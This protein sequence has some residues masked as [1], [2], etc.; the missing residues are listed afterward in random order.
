MKVKL[1]DIIDLDYLL[2]LD[3]QASTNIQIL[4]RTKR[5]R[6]IYQKIEPKPDNEKNLILSWLKLRKKQFL[7]DKKSKAQH[8]LP[9]MIFSSLYNYMG[10]LMLIFGGFVGITL[11]YSF[12]AYHGEKPINVALYIA[13]F[14]VLQMVLILIT[15]IALIRRYFIKSFENDVVNQGAFFQTMV[16]GFFFHSLPKWL[17]KRDWGIFKKNIDSLEYVAAIIQMKNREYKNLFFWPMF[18]LTSF[19]SLGFSMGALGGTFFRVLISDMAFGWQSTLIT[20]SERVFQLVHFMALPW[21]WLVSEVAAHPSLAQIEGSRIILKDGISVLATQDLISWWPF[22]CFSV[23]V[24]AVIPRLGLSIFSFFAQRRKI[25]TYVFTQPL[26]RQLLARMMSPVVDIESKETSVSQT[27]RKKPNL[28]TNNLESA[29]FKPD[30]NLSLKDQTIE[31]LLS[32]QV[33]QN[34][35]IEKIQSNIEKQLNFKAGRIHNAAF[36]PEND[37]KIIQQINFDQI[38]GILMVY[39]VWQSPIRGIQFYISQI[40][41]EM[42]K[43]KFLC[44][45]L[46]QD[47]SQEKLEVLENDINFDIWK[48]TILKLNHPGIIIKRYIEI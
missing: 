13:L 22:I 33:Y 18:S 40:R 42:P 47:A 6:E 48:K 16:S 19:F 31:I 24:Y 2:N 35:K 38:Q 1:Q 10:Y 45:Y 37:L 23:L 30:N 29:V 9:G 25:N 3:E 43:D 34:D 20:S 11:A 41:K 39:E 27:E 36:D 5:D 32:K 26:F 7:E 8:L 28:E 21:S 14:V 12:L 17:Q 44:L 46:T 15:L 4:S